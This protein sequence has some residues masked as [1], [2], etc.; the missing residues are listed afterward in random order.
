M[1]PSV[2]AS[3][4]SAEG[5]VKIGH[6]HNCII[7]YVCAWVGALSHQ[8]DVDWR[9]TEV[10]NNQWLWP[11]D[12]FSDD[13]IEICVIEDGQDGAEYFFLHQ[14][15]VFTGRFNDGWPHKSAILVD[16]FSSVSDLSAMLVLQV[17][18]DSV[19][20]EPVDDFSVIAILLKVLLSSVKLL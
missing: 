15:W 8:F 17:P 1:V 19:K 10:I 5:K 6:L 13:L 18:F 4:D 14:E 3:S 9:F 16:G 12:Y 11:W 20:M 2:S 7:D